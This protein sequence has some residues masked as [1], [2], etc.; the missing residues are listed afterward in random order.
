MFSV[1]KKFNAGFTLL[2]LSIVIAI[3]G[4]LYLVA[5]PRGDKVAHKARESVLKTNLRIVREC[6]DKYYGDNGEYPAELEALVEKRYIRSIPVDPITN[7][8]KTWVTI[9]S[10]QQKDDIFN[11]KSGSNSMSLEGTLYNQW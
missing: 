1:R 5:M 2:E 6:I 8:S 11:I 4:I 7:S 3:I 10:A 9:S